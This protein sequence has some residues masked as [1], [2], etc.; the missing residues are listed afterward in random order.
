MRH[1][2]FEANILFKIPSWPGQHPFLRRV[3]LGPRPQYWRPQHR[4]M[5]PS[6]TGEQLDDSKP[7]FIGSTFSSQKSYICLLQKWWNHSNHVETVFLRKADCTFERTCALE[8]RNSQQESN[9][10]QG[11]SLPKLGETR[12]ASNRKLRDHNTPELR[13]VVVSEFSVG[14]WPS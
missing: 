2:L 9:F 12:P 13:S 5:P 3:L 14:C 4:S 11:G 6:D 10:Q 7:G 8:Q 1:F